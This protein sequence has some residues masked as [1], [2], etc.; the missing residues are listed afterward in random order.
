MSEV[1]SIFTVQLG[2]F[3]TVA[4]LLL[5]V[6]CVLGGEALKILIC[7]LTEA[8]KREHFLGF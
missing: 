5:F 8:L 7:A 6:R 1:K 4:V 3:V 2:D